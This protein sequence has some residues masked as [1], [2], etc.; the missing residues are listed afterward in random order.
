MPV[1]EI[2]PHSA[3][4]LL[5]RR[6]TDSRPRDCVTIVSTSRHFA[7]PRAPRYYQGGIITRWGSDRLLKS[8]AVGR[9]TTRLGP[10]ARHRSPRSFRPT[11]TTPL[12]LV[13]GT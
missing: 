4:L 2:R 1:L 5:H 11:A 13:S 3:D 9:G 10:P 6:S 8:P 7:R 12:R